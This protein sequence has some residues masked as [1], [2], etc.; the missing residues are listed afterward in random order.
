MDLNKTET[1]RRTSSTAVAE[2]SKIGTI[3]CIENPCFSK[4]SGQKRSSIA[5]PECSSAQ[6]SEMHHTLDK[7][8]ENHTMCI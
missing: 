1:P 8:L 4:Q 6:I 7:V 3:R 5:V 2:V